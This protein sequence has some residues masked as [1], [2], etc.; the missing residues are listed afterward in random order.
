[1]P[2]SLFDAGPHIT[3]PARGIR[4]GGRET[5]SSCAP[6]RAQPLL[7]STECDECE[8]G[9]FSSANASATCAFCAPG[10]YTNAKHQTACKLCLRGYAAEVE[11]S[12]E[13]MK[14]SPARYS[15]VEG[16]P[17]CK[18]CPTGRF[19]DAPLEDGLYTD[20]ESCLENYF[21]GFG[22]VRG[23][24]CVSN[25]IIL[26]AAILFVCG[27]GT[28][29]AKRIWCRGQS[30]RVVV[31]T[32]VAKA[33]GRGRQKIGITG[34][35]RRHGAEDRAGVRGVD[36]AHDREPILSESEGSSSGLRFEE[37]GRSSQPVGGRVS[38]PRRQ[39]K[40]RQLFSGDCRGGTEDPGG[41]PG[42][43]LQ[44]VRGA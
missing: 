16:S 32:Q 14:C 33:S 30:I 15:N 24:E 39:R 3:P 18:S 1:M 4:G 21:A 26:V 10:S 9:R 25:V 40:R 28:Y 34:V 2:L 20:C 41:A 5:C 27:G 6:G 13:C 37:Y 42:A 7:G 23:G 43:R 36:A 11:G 38:P 22:K 8:I 19:A 12:S 44:T 29:I 17:E 35:V 31:R